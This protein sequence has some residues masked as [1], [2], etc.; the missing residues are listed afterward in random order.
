MSELENAQEAGKLLAEVL[1][2]GMT[3][4]NEGGGFTCREADN[5][6]TALILLGQPEAART[7]LEGHAEGDTDP[8]DEHTVAEGEGTVEEM[9]KSHVRMLASTHGVGLHDELNVPDD[10]SDE[11][12]ANSVRTGANSIQE[13]QH[14]KVWAYISSDPW[15]VGRA[16]FHEG[17]VTMVFDSAP[18]FRKGT[19]EDISGVPTINI[20]FADGTQLHAV[21][22]A[23][24]YIVQD[25]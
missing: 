2:D 7:W 16:G 1:G 24:T 20:T 18:E 13:G 8:E 23:V 11:P 4:S 5:L 15:P 6:A 9:V 21:P 17:V 22:Y 14:V 12:P 10:L 19:D 25:D 3:A